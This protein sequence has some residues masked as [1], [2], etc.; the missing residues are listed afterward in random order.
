MYIFRVKV[1]L[2]SNRNE[3]I[4]L[5]RMNDGRRETEI[6]S[7][8]SFRVKRREIF[9]NKKHINPIA[10]KHLV[11]SHAVAEDC[12]RARARDALNRIHGTKS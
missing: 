1:N 10:I 6:T 9:I 7:K 3:L 8:I 4:I 5:N 11:I 12:W 2:P